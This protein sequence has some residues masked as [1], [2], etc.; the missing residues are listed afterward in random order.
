MNKSMT[1]SALLAL[2]LAVPGLAQA[3]PEVEPN[4]PIASAQTLEIGDITV[5]GVATTGAIVEAVVGN[6]S[7]A[8]V[9]DLDFFWF[10]GKEGDIVT[11]DI[12]NGF[13]GAG[14][15]DTIIAL[16]GPAPAYTVLETRDDMPVDPGSKPRTALSSSTPDA[17]IEKFRLPA[18]GR[19][20]VAVSAF[21]QRWA[22][23]GVLA[24]TSPDMPKSNGTYT[25]IVSG[26][27]PASL[28][29]L[30]ISIEVKPGSNELV[31]INPKAKGKVPVALMG[32]REFSVDDVDTDS[33]TFGRSGDEDSLSRCATP[34][35]VNGDLWPDM[36]CHFENQA[37]NFASSDEG[38]I[39]RGKLEDGRKFEG[40][41]WLKAIPVKADD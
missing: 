20:T 30:Q 19:Y 7:G 24:T 37:A 39:L 41:G 35:D 25:L 4:H 28:P 38:A 13:K 21:Q 31:R 2:L 15:L 16:F 1:R 12:D 18:D 40:R 27:T 34:S 6:S 17:R 11:L 14:T 29:S 22:T 10:E 9:A 33:L 8:L 3:A 32:S 26:V 23:G 36:V 5:D